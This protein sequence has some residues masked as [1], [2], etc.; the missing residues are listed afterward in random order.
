[1]G[2]SQ[3][4]ITVWQ[5]P[6]S[7]TLFEVKWFDPRNG[8]ELQKGKLKKAKGGSIVDLHG[9]PSEPEKDWVLLLEKL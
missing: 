1:M 2:L 7:S 8:G 9:A 4:A 6:V 5:K 3:R